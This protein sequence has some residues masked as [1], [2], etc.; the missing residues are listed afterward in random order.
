MKDVLKSQHVIQF[1]ATGTA[2]AWFKWLD[3][4]RKKTHLSII[5]NAIEC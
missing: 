5:A 3:L 4:K 1:A 2:K